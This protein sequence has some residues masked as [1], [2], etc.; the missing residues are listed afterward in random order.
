MTVTLSDS[1]LKIMSVIWQQG[2]TA[3]AKDISARIQA[4]H[5]YTRGAIYTLIHRLAEKG[6]II[7]EEPGFICRSTIDKDE[8]QLAQTRSLINRLF[9]GN[10]DDL[11]ISLISNESISDDTIDRLRELVNRSSS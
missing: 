3:S 8:V 6:A 7:K 4:S 2:G 5:G 9:D 11:V 1:E 10:A